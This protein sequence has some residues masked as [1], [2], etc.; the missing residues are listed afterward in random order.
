MNPIRNYQEVSP[1]LLRYF[2]RG[3]ITNNFLS[4]DD[5]RAEVKE[6]RL[7]YCA[8]EDFLNLYV[9]RDGFYQLYFHAFSQDTCFPAVNV[10]LIAEM[11]GENTG[12]LEKNG[13]LKILDRVKLEL[14]LDIPP[15]K[16]GQKAQKED[17]RD[18]FQLLC[19]SFSSETGALPTFAQVEKEC[20]DGFYYKI[21]S[22]GELAGILRFGKSGKTAQIKHLCVKE[23]FRGQKIGKQL[24]LDFLAENP[25]AT[26]WT[27]AANAAALTLYHSLGFTDC[28]LKSTVYR[29]DVTL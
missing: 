1:L 13:F 9:K 29:K 23:A 5:Y 28:E 2:K 8:K 3:V 17:T 27:G 4:A 22:Q 18:I 16:A 25:K 7:F 10:P 21:M 14:S 15:K 26:V 19:R 6:G 20:E 11:A 12:I 24:V